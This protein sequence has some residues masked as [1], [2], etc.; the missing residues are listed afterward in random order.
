MKH[1]AIKTAF[2]AKRVLAVSLKI[3]ASTVWNIGLVMYFSGNLTGLYIYA[4]LVLLTALGMSLLLYIAIMEDPSDTE[5]QRKIIIFQDD[6]FWE[7]FKGNKR[8][9]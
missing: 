8:S 4:C 3:F 2:A 6:A 9:Q 7:I 1:Q 5:R